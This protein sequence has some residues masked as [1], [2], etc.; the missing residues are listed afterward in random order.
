MHINAHCRIK[1]VFV[2]K[3]GR[4]G[5]QEPG[6]PFSKLL[7]PHLMQQ[8][9]MGYF[10]KNLKITIDRKQ[11]WIVYFY[12]DFFVPHQNDVATTKIIK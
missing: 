7:D 10:H 1:G 12:L 4:I 9:F 8:W 3:L 11:N 5:K 2:Y 6:T